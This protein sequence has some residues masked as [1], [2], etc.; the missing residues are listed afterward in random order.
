[1]CYWRQPA[2]SSWG[3]DLSPSSIQP[4][5]SSASFSSYDNHDDDRPS[6][7]GFASDVDPTSTTCKSFNPTQSYKDDRLT[8]ANRKKQGSPASRANGTRNPTKRMSFSM[9]TNKLQ[10]S[11][12]GRLRKLSKVN[13]NSTIAEMAAQCC[14]SQIFSFTVS[15]GGVSLFNALFLSNLWE[16]HYKSFTAEK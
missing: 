15:S 2:D 8:V 11:P 13:N 4:P 16:Y 14:T 10:S 5:A 1:M 6:S 7:P 3:G 9:F 12:A